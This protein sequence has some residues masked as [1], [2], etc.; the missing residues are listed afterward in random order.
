MKSFRSKHSEQGNTPVPFTELLDAVQL[1][2]HDRPHKASHSSIFPEGHSED[3]HIKEISTVKITSRIT[4]N[5]L[6]PCCIG[7][8]QTHQLMGR[9]VSKGKREMLPFG[10]QGSER[11][12]SLKI[13]IQEITG[14][15]KLQ[16]LQA[17][18]R[19]PQQ[20]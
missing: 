20:K 5:L 15:K 1:I 12:T 13:Q 14:R 4:R 8:L 2:S 11:I 18:L 3:S 16:N 17:Q 19:M 10:V 7:D 9:L 6:L